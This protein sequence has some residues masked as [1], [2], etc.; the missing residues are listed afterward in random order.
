MCQI[1]IF[2][3]FTCEFTDIWH[4]GKEKF[5][6]FYYPKPKISQPEGFGWLILKGLKNFSP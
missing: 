6:A 3:K 1:F 2:Q 5:A 4:D